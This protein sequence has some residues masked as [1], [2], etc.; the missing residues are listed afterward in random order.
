MNINTWPKKIYNLVSIKNDLW[1]AIILFV[2]MQWMYFTISL[3]MPIRKANWDTIFGMDTPRVISDLTD[4]R[5]SHFRTNLHP[6]FVLIL[7]PIGSSTASLLRA[8]HN[9][10]DFVPTEHN[11]PTVLATM[12][13]LDDE[14]IASASFLSSSAGALGVA[15]M[16]L[17]LRSLELRRLPAIFLSTAFAFSTASLLFSVIPET[18]IFGSATLLF[19]YYVGLKMFKIQDKR[20]TLSHA[21]FLVVVPAAAVLS[22]SMTITNFLQVVIMLAAFAIALRKKESLLE[23]NIRDPLFKGAMC[24]A[25][26]LSLIP[27]KFLP[28]IFEP[29]IVLFFAVIF[30]WNNK[31]EKKEVKIKL[32]S[33]KYALFVAIFALYMMGSMSLVQRLIY[34][35]SGLPLWGLA[36]EFQYMNFGG[37]NGDSLIK[38]SGES[39]QKLES[40]AT[41]LTY[42]KNLGVVS[43]NFAVHGLIAPKLKSPNE[44]FDLKR[45]FSWVSLLWLLISY[46][47]MVIGITK[48]FKKIPYFLSVILGGIA[49]TLL[50]HSIY[51]PNE[52]ILYVPHAAF[53]FFI[54]MGMGLRGI[55][56]VPPRLNIVPNVISGFVLIGALLH[57]IPFIQT[58]AELVIKAKA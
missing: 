55:E 47:L 38:R 18:Y 41:I 36:Q 58:L 3:Q 54:L 26:T 20:F 16:Y 40:S 32:N 25:F 7:N 24:L 27:R 43:K 13:M 56:Q 33:W 37:V 30:F 49:S 19:A 29:T 6:L 23:I 46:A 39:T 45:G 42:V 1:M 14:D 50:M 11:G 53:L 9:P 52:S 12:N 17:I 2:L 35:S 44:F 34:P 10:R 8:V 22:I 21:F 31:I 48:G 57:N 15:F 51:G 4:Y 28:G 5:G